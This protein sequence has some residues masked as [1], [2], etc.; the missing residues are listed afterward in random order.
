M[1]SLGRGVG[2]REGD[3]GDGGGVGAQGRRVGALGGRW[4][5]LNG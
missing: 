2:G 4:L 3:V 1:K 5:G